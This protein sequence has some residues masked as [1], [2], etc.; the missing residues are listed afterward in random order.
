VRP[1]AIEVSAAAAATASEAN[2]CEAELRSVAFLGDHY[3][4]QLGVGSLELLA[5][6][7]TPVAGG[8]LA[9]HIP[10]SA[11]AVLD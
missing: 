4:Y 6:T 7:T 3:E 5:Q 2:R 9:V 11:C 10:P 8:R 1:E